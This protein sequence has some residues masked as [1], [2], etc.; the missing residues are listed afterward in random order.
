MTLSKIWRIWET[1]AVEIKESIPCFLFLTNFDID[2]YDVIFY[3][4]F[5]FGGNMKLVKYGSKDGIKYGLQDNGRIVVEPKYSTREELMK[6]PY[7]VAKN[8]ETNEKNMQSR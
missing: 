7:I 3:H 1:L 5:K 4:I 6:D 8:N 2:K